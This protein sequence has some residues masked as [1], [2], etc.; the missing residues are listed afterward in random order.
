MAWQT[1]INGGADIWAAVVPEPGE[2]P[3][4]LAPIVVAGSKANEWSPSIASGK[5]EIL[6]AYDTYE[7]GN[8]DV[9]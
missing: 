6:V 4:K 2:S 5:G 3:K 7:A 8:Y 1:W 9:R